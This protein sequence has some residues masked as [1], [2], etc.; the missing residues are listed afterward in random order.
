M[1]AQYSP[2]RRNNNVYN[3]IRIHLPR[4]K[5]EGNAVENTI[6]P[7]KLDVRAFFYSY[8]LFLKKNID[9]YTIRVNSIR[10]IR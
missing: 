4:T 6:D 9:V 3:S 10:Y 5:Y 7:Q 8:F 1:T 2:D